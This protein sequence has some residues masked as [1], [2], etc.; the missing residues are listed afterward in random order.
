MSSGCSSAACV[1][2]RSRHRINPI[3]STARRGYGSS[4]RSRRLSGPRMLSVISA[5]DFHHA[6]AAVFFGVIVAV[7]YARFQ[8]LA[9]DSLREQPRAAVA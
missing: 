1:Q 9:M 4:W 8:R 5:S 2:A 6:A 7:L 3:E